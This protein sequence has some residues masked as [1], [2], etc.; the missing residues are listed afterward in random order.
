M[1]NDGKTNAWWKY[2]AMVAKSHDIDYVAKVDSDVI[3][4]ISHFMDFIITDLPPYPYNVRT[5]GG[6]MLHNSNRMQRGHLYASGQ[7]VFFS[8]DMAAFVS[9][10]K[11]HRA[12]LKESGIGFQESK[13]SNAEDIDTGTLAW[14]HPY[15]LKIIFM[16][17]RVPWIHKIKEESAWRSFWEETDGII[18]LSRVVGK[19][20]HR[21]KPG[22]WRLE[23]DERNKN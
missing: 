2:S 14:M 19:F 1:G 20:D 15:P 16:N 13:V 7:F 9:D 3:L 23:Y 10:D 22:E 11:L 6:N 4:S 17:Q 8:R 5:Y 18:P 21:I 12:S